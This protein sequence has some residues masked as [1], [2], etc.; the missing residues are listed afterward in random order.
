MHPEKNH[1]FKHI[2]NY[3]YWSSWDKDVNACT[4]ACA[5]ANFNPPADKR[6]LW[7]LFIQLEC[8]L[9]TVTKDMSLPIWWMISLLLFRK[10]RNTVFWCLTSFIPQTCKNS[11]SNAQRTKNC[12][13]THLQFKTCIWIM[14]TEYNV[15]SK[16]DKIWVLGNIL[17]DHLTT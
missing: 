6:L 5:L 8:I 16:N 1:N 12:A 2:W 4:C 10:K 3:C 9:Y 14:Q 15:L 11:I 17:C 7:Q 13:I